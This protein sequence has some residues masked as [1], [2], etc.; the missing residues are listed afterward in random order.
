[1]KTPERI[2]LLLL[3][4][5]TT[6]CI[7]VHA[8]V[9]EWNVRRGFSGW[10]HSSG[11]GI[12]L[13]N[14]SCGIITENIPAEI[15]S[16]DFRLNFRTRNL[17]NDPGTRHGY[18]DGDNRRKAVLFPGWRLRLIYADAHNPD[19]ISISFRTEEKDDDINAR[20]HL[21][22]SASING[23]AFADTVISSGVDIY[24]GTNAFSLSSDNGCLY[25]RG[26]NREYNR[27]LSIPALSVPPR[28]IQFAAEPAGKLLIS[29]IALW[30]NDD[31]IIQDSFSI[32][33]L[34]ELLAHTTDANARCWQM[35]DRMLEEKY[36]RRGGDYTIALLPF[37]K[38]YRVIYLDGAVKN[39]SKWKSGM[40]KGELIATP[41][42]GIYNAN[43]L[44]AGMTP[45]DSE[46]KAIFKDNVLTLKFPYL[47][48]EVR[49]VKTGNIPDIHAH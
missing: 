8:D 38:G 24:K 17:H 16:S 32:E 23:N 39:S 33:R 28:T 14:D 6:A 19:T 11:E 22:V 36:L 30:Q 9:K 15:H 18:S 10:H 1:M 42:Q 41:F 2:L 40:I 49:F 29:D 34:K 43:W 35:F 47:D 46:I 21:R 37:E 4:L 12:L 25:L 3:I 5:L 31:T 45:I 7:D 13:Y 27:I 48:S 20:Q 44:D 26:G